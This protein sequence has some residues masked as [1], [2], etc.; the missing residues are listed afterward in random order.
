[1][2]VV[3]AG[4]N[5]ITVVSDDPSPIG[6]GAH[7]AYFETILNFS[8]RLD[9]RGYDFRGTERLGE[10]LRDTCEYLEDCHI[11]YELDE[12]ANRIVTR[13]RGAEARLAESIAA[14]REVLDNPPSSAPDVP[15]FVRQLLPH[16]WLP[17]NHLLA[18]SHAANFSVPGAGKT[19]I[20]LA[21][22]QRLL[23]DGAVDCL[24][25]VGPG[26]AF[27]AWEDE[28][29]ACIG[30]PPSVVRLSGSPEER[31]VAYERAL[32]CELILVTYHTANN[33][34]ARLVELLRNRKAILVLDESHY[35]KGSGAFADAVLE[36][37]PEA[38]RR[39]IL[40][41]TP[42]PNGYLDLWSQATFLWPDQHLFGNRAQFRSSV[43]T[44][45]GQETAK[46]R[47][48]PL[49]SRVRKSDLGLP[50]PRFV[51]VPVS[52]GVQQSRIYEVLAS[53]TLN[54]LG[55]LPTERVV[56]RQWRRSRMIRLL[57]AASN[58]SLLAQD[59][60]EFSLPPEDAL[61]LPILEVLRS[62]LTYEMPNKLLM[63]NELTRRLLSNSTEKVIIWTHFVRNVQ[64]L[65]ELLQDLGALPLY[66]A[67]PRDGP[68]DEEFT[69]EKHVRAFK[70]DPRCKVLVGNPGAAAESISLHKV[71][72]HAIY[73]DRT[74]NAGQYI[75]SRER[76]HRVGLLPDEHVTYHLLISVR[77]ID[78]TVDRRLDVKEQRMLAL[79]DDPDLPGVA[80][81]VATDHVSGEDEAEE[82]VDFLEV[83][84]D[85]QRIR[86][87]PLSESVE[88]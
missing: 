71:C 72:H 60:I 8:R 31:E 54:D 27:M 26:S 82:E 25:V 6:A 4:R 70:T 1:M 40:T 68:D 52:L 32:R 65:C 12:T 19:T 45:S 33:D 35:I 46:N 7:R 43:A 64:F 34:R 38:T 74:F 9:G 58:P 81:E 37:A 23:A 73:V 42:I 3:S 41:G 49:F 86:S 16:Q 62:Y 85:L 55:L 24:V 39:I 2:I 14:G 66:G 80:L 20:V 59:S 13:A 21:A 44:A 83:I 69:R 15:N 28:F 75:Q 30:R 76:I 48:R 51:K 18:V 77:T 53:R 84:R 79:L 87:H 36:I 63:A 17:V 29:E 47:I 11:Q 5:Y 61:D 57:Q 88:P 67:V 22:F 56:V 50:V 78:E 10:L